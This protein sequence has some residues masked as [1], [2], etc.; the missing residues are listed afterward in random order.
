MAAKKE[1]AKLW[2]L[3]EMFEDLEAEE[4]AAARPKKT[5]RSEW[6]KPWLQKR[7]DPL[8]W[9]LLYTEVEESDVSKFKNVFRISP[10]L[11]D[12]ILTVVGPI[13]E[14]RDTHMR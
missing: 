12:E 8:A 10:D 7:D 1:I 6:A 5:V 9:S 3:H 13:I 2:I 4:V 11:F 14:K